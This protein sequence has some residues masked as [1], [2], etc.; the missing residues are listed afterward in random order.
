MTLFALFA[1]NS[2]DLR[3]LSVLYEFFK[4]FEIIFGSVGIYGT[5]FCIFPDMYDVPDVTESEKDRGNV[6]NYVPTVTDYEKICKPVAYFSFQA[7]V[8]DARTAESVAVNVFRNVGA[9][10]YAVLVA[11]EGKSR[12]V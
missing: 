12:S 1:G 5:V 8:H 9:V 11:K 10:I 2:F 4:L 7:P 6:G 3:L